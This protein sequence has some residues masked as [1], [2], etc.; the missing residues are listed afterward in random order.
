VTLGAWRLDSR[1]PKCRTASVDREE[2]DGVTVGILLRMALL[3][4][5]DGNMAIVGTWY[6]E[7][8]STLEIT[9][10]TGRSCGQVSARDRLLPLR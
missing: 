8:G 1:F 9:A 2:C 4:Q 5:E 10:L 7:L 6:N 3:I